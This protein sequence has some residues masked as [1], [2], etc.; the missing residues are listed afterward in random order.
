MHSTLS[1]G[2]VAVLSFLRSASLWS[3]SVSS[4]YNC[5][6]SLVAPAR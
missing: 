5:G 6:G 2:C 3:G 1:D 4:D